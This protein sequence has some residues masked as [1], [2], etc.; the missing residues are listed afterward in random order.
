M[1]AVQTPMICVMISWVIYALANAASR[2]AMYGIWV[3]P[4]VLLPATAPLGLLLGL[5]AFTLTRDTTRSSRG[6][7]RNEC[8]RSAES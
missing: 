8:L 3:V 1:G 6:H 2:E 7:A 5:A 4:L